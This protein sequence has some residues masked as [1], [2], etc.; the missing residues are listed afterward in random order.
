MPGKK[1]R[2]VYRKSR[3]RSFHGVHVS[4]VHHEE[5]STSTPNY[6]PAKRHKS[7]EKLSSN[8]PLLKVE[9]TD[10]ITRNRSFELG[11]LSQQSPSNI[12]AYGYKLIDST[13][14]Q[15]CILDA[16]ICKNCRDLKSKL[17]LW[18]DNN[19]RC[20]LQERLFLKCSVCEHKV[21][22]NTSK[23][24]GGKSGGRSEVNIRMVQAG[25]ATGKNVMVSHHF[26]VSFLFYLLK[27]E[28]FWIMKFYPKYVLNAERVT[29]GIKI[30]IN[31]WRGIKH[32]H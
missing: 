31:M 30:Q 1:Q 22:F 21:F 27:Q 4:Q 23:K 25:L 17:Q 16:S 29:L 5:P 3:K 7:L 10:I 20:G 19:K 2:S 9:S 12:K 26:M 18:Q 14:L 32:M 8:C 13:L 24:V 11:I 15:E 28:R 6:S